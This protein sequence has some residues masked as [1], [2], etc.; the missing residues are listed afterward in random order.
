MKKATPYVVAIALPC[1]LNSCVGPGLMAMQGNALGAIANRGGGADQQ[2]KFRQ[3]QANTV[4]QG[5]AAG[6]G[7][8]ALAGGLLAQRFG[9]AGVLAGAVIGGAIGNAVGQNV[10]MKK[11]L[12]QTTEA[13]LDAC[14]NAS[15]KENRRAQGRINDL[16]NQL[17]TYKTKISNARAKNDT[18]ALAGYKKEL[19]TLD[20]S[21]AGEIKN[22]NTGIGLQDQ[23]AAKAGA[24]NSRYAKLSSTNTE[25]KQSRGQL[26]SD[27]REV[28]SLMNS[29]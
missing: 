1:L 4:N 10:A 9:I 29:L 3:D 8:G 25:L 15:I 7:I 28:A 6:A 27:R 22:L 21:Y 24:G 26:E 18:R 14:I 20:N 13:N 5:T 12:A 11:A 19:Q 23:V 2:N 17:A 16:R